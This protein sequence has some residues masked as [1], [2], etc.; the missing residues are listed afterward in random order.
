[1]AT[2]DALKRA[3]PGRLVGVSLDAAGA[4][5]MRLALQTR[6]QHIRREKAT[7]NICTAQVLLAVLAGMYAVWHGPLGLTRIAKRVN[8]QARLLA[9]AAQQGGYGVRFENFFDTITI[10]AG[11]R[12]DALM[13]QA[14]AAGFNFRRVDATGVAIALDET[15]TRTDLEALATLLGGHDALAPHSIPQ[16]LQRKS[17]FLQ[18]TVFSAHHAE[19]E[20]LRYL[21][22]LED[23]DIALNRSMIPLGSCTMKLN[24]TA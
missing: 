19:H 17:S 5:A 12:A 11:D 3:M 1:M 4:P 10:N 23:K 14:V 8:L 21:K 6:E 16:A 13:Q 20:M 24:A 22:R 7:S 15:V 9:S 18:Q 2:K